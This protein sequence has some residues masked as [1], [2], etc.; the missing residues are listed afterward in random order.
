MSV[1]EVCDKI[2]VWFEFQLNIYVVSLETTNLFDPSHQILIFFWRRNHLT[3][4][5]TFLVKE[6]LRVSRKMH[7]STHIWI[8]LTCAFSLYLLV[9]CELFCLL[10]YSL[11]WLICV[12][13]VVECT[14]WNMVSNHCIWQPLLRWSFLSM[15]VVILIRI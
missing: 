14:S 11:S 5:I 15:W 6:L 8:L 2:F 10:H 12:F 9:R 3:L 13:C 1:F 7:V 4:S